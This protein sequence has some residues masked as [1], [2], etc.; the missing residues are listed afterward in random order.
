[1]S[2]FIELDELSFF[3]EV[4]QSNVETLFNVLIS[5]SSER[6]VPV[7]W[8]TLGSWDHDCNLAMAHCVRPWSFESHFTHY[9][10]YPDSLWRMA[11]ICQND[12]RKTHM[13]TNK[14]ILHSW[15]TCFCYWLDNFEGSAIPQGWKIYGGS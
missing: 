5:V 14:G 10:P 15:L 8:T 1:M 12:T 3:N 11:S 9:L 2:Y 13:C 4:T 7:P 6:T